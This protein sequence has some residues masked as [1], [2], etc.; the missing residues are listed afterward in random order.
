[1]LS[2]INSTRL[3][4]DRTEMARLTKTEAVEQLAAQ[5]TVLAT[6]QSGQAFEL[7]PRSADGTRLTALTGR[8]RLASATQATVRVQDQTGRPWIVTLR[9]EAAAMHSQ[10]TAETVLRATGLRL[11]P[12]H[13]K[14]ERVAI[15]G[16]AS[17]TAINCQNVVDADVV[18]A[19]VF[20]LAEGGVAIAT[21]RLLRSGDRLLLQ[22]RFFATEIEAE[23]RV[24]RI[25]ERR[26]GVVEA[27]CR[28]I[29]LTR[30]QRA[31]VQDLL[32][33][34]NTGE[35]LNIRSLLSD[36]ES[37]RAAASESA[38]LWR[39]VLRKAS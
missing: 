11:D 35:S 18:E 24:A 17:L 30:E 7:Q 1:M 8:L 4:A 5:G 2:L 3:T 6:D 10:D 15:N 16:R 22:A 19:R 34:R 39:R 37:E 38:P 14:A 32:A 26:D 31:T 13:R 20:D 27:G 21:Q 12:A 9:V 23:V 33:H 29:A 25:R 36:G 28:F